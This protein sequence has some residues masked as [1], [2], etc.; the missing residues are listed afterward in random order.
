MKKALQRVG[1]RI[2]A[3]TLHPWH[4]GLLLGAKNA[5]ICV[6]AGVLMVL[7]WNISALWMLLYGI[8]PL[9]LVLFWLWY[10]RHLLSMLRRMNLHDSLLISLAGALPFMLLFCVAT[11]VAF[12]YSSGGDVTLGLVGFAYNTMAFSIGAVFLEFTIIVFG[13]HHPFKRR[14]HDG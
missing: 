3:G 5:L 8:L 14:A 9:L 4:I 7:S 13:L 10:A 11:V 6:G 2:H 12:A 1:D